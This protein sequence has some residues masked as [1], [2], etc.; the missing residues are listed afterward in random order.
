MRML[1][2]FYAQNKTILCISILAFGLNQLFELLVLSAHS[3]SYEALCSWDCPWY[4]STVR[5]G[6]D[7]APHG[8]ERGDAANW[9]FFPALAIVA[10]LFSSVFSMA[11]PVALILTSKVFFLLSIFSFLKL[12]SVYTP[13]VSPWVCAAVLVLNP[14]SLYGNVGYTESMFLFFTCLSLYSLK[15]GRFLGAGVSGA[16][17]SSVRPTGM[18]IV[19]AMIVESFKRM[20]SAT[21]DQRL[22]MLVG[23]MLAPLGLAIFMAFL[24]WRM[25]DAMAFSHVQI[26]WERV[27]SNP[28]VHLYQ[29]L[30]AQ[31]FMPLLWAWMSFVALLM[32]AYLAWRRE[33]ALAGFSL[34]ATLIP[35]ATGLSAMPRYLW[36]QAPLLLVLVQWLSAGSEQL[37][38]V[39]ARAIPLFWALLL[40]LSLWGLHRTYVAWLMNEAFII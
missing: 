12:A 27:P 38:G 4:S 34:C 37:K 14:Y 5:T 29:G 10:R 13:R 1:K 35:L 21:P 32:V 40:P 7:L 17:L 20:P 6:Y 31:E 36:W 2:L 9:A 28:F 26:A 19:V 3:A 23:V 16:M 15:R 22:R 24:Y 11:P 18:F 30:I 39:S 33:Y 8:H 25:G